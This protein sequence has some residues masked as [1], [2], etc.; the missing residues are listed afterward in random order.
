MGS[1]GT[2]SKAPSPACVT[3]TNTRFKTSFLLRIAS[4]SSLLC[5][6]SSFFRFFS[7][8]SSAFFWFCS[9]ISLIW[10]RARLM[11]S[12]TISSLS[13]ARRSFAAVR[14]SSMDVPFSIAVVRICT[15]CFCPSSFFRA[16]SSNCSFRLRSAF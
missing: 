7:A 6:C 2:S 12:E 4:R 15:A 14:A 5:F 16:V 1:Q 13:A 3:G 9:K 10:S 8:I 11:Q